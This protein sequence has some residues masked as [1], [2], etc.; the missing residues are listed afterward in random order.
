M[1]SKTTQKQE[2][3][4]DLKNGI[5][6]TPIDALREYGCFRLSAVIFNLKQEGHDIRTT[7]VE[8]TSGNGKYASYKLHKRT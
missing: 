2:I 4:N 6:I 1:M 3:L 7:M 5:S 8:Q